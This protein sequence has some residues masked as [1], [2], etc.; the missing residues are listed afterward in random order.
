[1]AAAPFPAPGRRDGYRYGGTD[2]PANPHYVDS[3]VAVLVPTGLPS[4]GPVNLV[5]FFHGWNSSIDD[6]VQT[7]RGQIGASGG[8]ARVEHVR[9]SWPEDAASSTISRRRPRGR[10]G[11]SDV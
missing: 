9:L 11:L 4:G 2:Y 10:G 6:A 8:E 1:M 5:F 7:G 3:S